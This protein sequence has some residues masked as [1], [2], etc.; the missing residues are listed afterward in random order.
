[1]AKFCGVM[2]EVQVGRSPQNDLE[3]MQEPQQ[4]GAGHD[5]PTRPGRWGGQGG[6]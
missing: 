5:H 3:E 2:L 4:Q 1:M 6:R